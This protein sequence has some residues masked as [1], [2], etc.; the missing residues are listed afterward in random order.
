MTELIHPETGEVVIQMTEDEARRATERIRLAL[1]RVSTAWAD[2]VERIADAYQRRADLALGYD[3]WA[4]YARAELTPSHPIATEVRRELVS[5]LSAQGMSTR[6]IAPTVGVQH[7]A[8][9]KDL[10]RESGVSGGHT[11]AEPAP[12]GA[13][14][15]TDW[16]TE[17]VDLDIEAEQ[18]AD[19]KRTDHRTVTGLD[20]KTYTRPAPKPIS[21]PTP[22]DEGMTTQTGG[23][24]ALPQPPKYGGNR[25][26]PAQV[27][28]KAIDALHGLTMATAELSDLSALTD[29]QA[30][31]ATSDLSKAIRELNRIRNL[32]KERTS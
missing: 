15:V 27:L 22:K 10:R 18:W 12:S 23:T 19:E 1:D 16:T 13:V 17:E 29:E 9:A 25:R 6:A 7:S 8:V 5:M 11:S 32:I 28:E 2:L 3:S 26:K 24:F 20:G 14:D 21:C 30:A 4:E 31:R